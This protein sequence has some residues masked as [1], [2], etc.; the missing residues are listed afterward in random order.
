MTEL[1]KNTV[2]ALSWK[3]C[4]WCFPNIFKVVNLYEKTNKNRRI[5][6]AIYG[7]DRCRIYLNPN[8]THVN[9]HIND[10]KNP[11]LY[12]HIDT[13]KHFCLILMFLLSLQGF[14]ICRNSHIFYFMYFTS[15]SKLAY[16][17]TTFILIS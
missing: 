10:L 5:G 9:N 12:T 13:L 1:L 17:F 14:K 8:K 4:Y 16:Y 15:L 6:M 7:F 3:W 2:S 11:I